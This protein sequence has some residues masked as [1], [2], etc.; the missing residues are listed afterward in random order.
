[1]A[2]KAVKAAL[3][4]GDNNLLHAVKQ[5]FGSQSLS[6]L[7]GTESFV[8]FKNGLDSITGTESAT[9]GAAFNKLTVNQ[10]DA[11]SASL[12]RSAIPPQEM[13][14]LK[15]AAKDLAQVGGMEGFSL[16]QSPGSEQQLRAVNL[17]LNAQSHLQTAAA[18]ELFRTITVKY[19]DE[20]AM[21]KVRA[22][23]LG[24]YAYGNSAWQSASELRPIFGLLRTG[25]MFKDDVLAL[26]PVYPEDEEA[27]TRSLFV[28]EALATPREVNYADTDAYGRESHLTQFLKVP[29]TI[30]NLLGLSQAPGQRPWT[31]TDE[32]ESNSITIRTLLATAKVGT[33]TQA[34][35]FFI[36]TG[37]MS[38]NTFGPTTTSQSS[39]D[40]GLNMHIRMLPGFSVEDKDGNPIGETLFANY[41]AAGYEPLLNIS[42][43]GNYQR[44]T[45]ELRLN[46]GTVEIAALRDLANPNVWISMGKAT[47]AQKDLLRGLVEGQVVGAKATFNASNT[48]RG[49][50]GYRIE[51]FDATKRLSVRR[52]SP[53]SVKY[54]V[55]SRDVN[56]ESLDFAI[57][58]MGIVINNQCSKIAFDMAL[59]HL[60]Y[61]TSI[62]GAPVVGNN[63][64]SNVLPGQHFV[65]A[66]AVNRS[67]K[68]EDVV[69]AQNNAE[70]YASVS[71]ALSNEIADI[72]AALNTKS[73]LA[74]IKEYGGS[75]QNDWSIICHQNLARFL[76]REGDARTLGNGVKLEVFETNFDSMIGK[77]LVVPAQ[78]STAE[79]INPL[80]GVGVNISKENIVVQGSVHRENQ[81]YGV[82]MTMPTFRHWPLNPVIGCLVVEDAAAFLGGEG[83]LSKLASQ[84]IKVDGLKPGLA[85]VE[86]AIRDGEPTPPNP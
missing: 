2:F 52:N 23:G 66:S 48:S 46:S 73:G 8:D 36:N 62:D 51:V 68:I 60:K 6:A 82:V 67:I 3:Q 84:R 31:T 78:T 19:E 20:G 38:N 12:A 43:G 30:P 81:E 71:A 40:R 1:M 33:A 74:A 16:Q 79:T 41:K 70:V 65:T 27:D 18:E 64:G 14:E 53:V 76:F 85:G 58:Q 9:F 5:A 47:A 17:T 63:Q 7:T 75:T 83:L 13:E 11:V 72:A 15:A 42:V 25:E 80:A 24:N 10:H 54:P 86:D 37:T 69:S 39:D 45:N 32:I 34:T 21:L 59:D 57:Q 35:P 44:Q 22:A 77:I 56:Q 61:I 55:D 49:N 4:S 26:V 28:S 29:C 50:F